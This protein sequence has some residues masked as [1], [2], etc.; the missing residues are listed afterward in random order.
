MTNGRQ[1]GHFTTSVS[2]GTYILVGIGVGIAAAA[3]A[4]LPMAIISGA[5]W[6]ATL[7]YWAVRA[8]QQYAAGG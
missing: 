8:L 2:G 6:P 1:G 3:T 4:S 5:F 7:G